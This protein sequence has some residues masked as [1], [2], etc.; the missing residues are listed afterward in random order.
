M[1][2]ANLVSSTIVRGM[3]KFANMVQDAILVILILRLEKTYVS[4]PGKCQ[5]KKFEVHWPMKDNKIGSLVHLLVVTGVV[6]HGIM[7]M[8]VHPHSGENGEP[9]GYLIVPFWPEIAFS[10]NG[11][12]DQLLVPLLLTC[13]EFEILRNVAPRCCNDP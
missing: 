2:D 11:T 9:P 6:P 1:L 3:V 4:A 10:S 12:G 13:M 5:R 8:E 7:G